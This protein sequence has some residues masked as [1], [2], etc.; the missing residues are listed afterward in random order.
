MSPHASDKLEEALA[1][2]QRLEMREPHRRDMVAALLRAQPA[3]ESAAPRLA[4]WRLIAGLSWAAAAG[5]VAFAVLAR[6]PAE[7]KRAPVS[8]ASPGLTPHPTTAPDALLHLGARVAILHPANARIE[9]QEV[10]ARLTRIR[11]EDGR[12]TA[13]LFAGTA[14]YRLQIST[15]DLVAVAVGTIFAVERSGGTSR[16]RVREGVV[17]VLHSEREHRVA[18]GE[19][20]D[21]LRGR[22]EP[23]AVALEAEALETLALPPPPRRPDARTTSAAPSSPVPESP[24]DPAAIWREA[25]LRRGAGAD[26][27]A[28]ELL[29]GLAARRDPTWSPLALAELVRLHA[30]P[31]HDP[32]QAIE[33]ADE[34]LA[35]YG[36]HELR[37]EVRLLSC[38][39]HRSM[40]RSPPGFCDSAPAP[41]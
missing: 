23:D 3:I 9:V 6:Q 36:D 41:R 15:R 37:R 34:F 17:R 13:R 11:L 1:A 5:A 33:R 31:L 20:Y 38:A 18:A 39:A 16:V 28:A 24:P 4:P 7:E 30:G 29:E 35:R 12:V 14:P 19:I 40:G 32:E 2:A 27:E 25:R 26:R 10:D 8:L 22:V 21:A